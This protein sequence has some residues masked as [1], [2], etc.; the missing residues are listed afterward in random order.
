MDSPP[1]LFDQYAARH[2][3]SK[4]M[5]KCALLLKSYADEGKRLWEAEELLGISHSS[6]QRIARKMLI[7]FVDYRP[8][9]ALEK[10]GEPR[11]LPGQRDIA[12]PASDLPLFA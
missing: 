4:G 6:A 10:K 11:P 5:A 3:L 12:K 9:A 2:G 8:Y 7:D 1:Y